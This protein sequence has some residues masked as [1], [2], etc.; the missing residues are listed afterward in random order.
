MGKGQGFQLTPAGSFICLK[1]SGTGDRLSVAFAGTT[2]QEVPA[3]FTKSDQLIIH[4]FV[5][6]FA[7]LSDYY[8][9]YV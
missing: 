5:E 8:L 4:F 9:V 3:V 7:A 6:G 1:F 2:D